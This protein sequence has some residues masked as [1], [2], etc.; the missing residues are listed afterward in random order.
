MDCGGLG[1]PTGC[2][3]PSARPPGNTEAHFADCRRHR[4]DFC[5]CGSHN[6]LSYSRATGRGATPHDASWLA[7]NDAEFSTVAPGSPALSP[8]GSK[9]AFLTGGIQP[10]NGSG[11]Q[12]KLETPQVASTLSSWSSDG[13]Y[14][15][16]SV[17]NNTTRFD[18]YYFDLKGNRNLTPFL[19]SPANER[20]AVLSPNGKWL[21]YESDESGRFEVYVT[22]FPEHGGK[23][24]VSNG[25]GDFPSWSRDGKQ[26]YYSSG[27]KLMGV[28]I[29]NAEKFEFG[30]PSPLP[31]HLN[32]FAALGPVA[33]GQRFPAL[34]PLNSQSNPQ[35]VILNWTGTLKQ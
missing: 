12:E 8:D 3:R 28:P 10:T 29:Q 31:I 24:Q 27:D 30:A 21:A 2:A 23:W 20:Y 15:F 19:N 17:Q 14:I 5:R 25:G 13:R 9:L 6:F 26:L 11:N 22:A 18:V 34:K 4:L 16:L 7:P 32:E 1:Q 33:P 35:E